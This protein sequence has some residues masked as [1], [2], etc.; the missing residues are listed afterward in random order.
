MDVTDLLAEAYGRLPDLVGAAVD[1]L[2]PEQLRQPP[3]PGANTVGWLIW[4]LTR[5]QD[6]GVADLLGEEQVWVS[7]DWAGR[8]GLTADPNDTG[9]GYTTEQVLACRPES[10]QALLD[11]HRAVAERTGAYLRGLRP[12]DLDR[13][14][15][16]NWD[17]PVTAG[18]R[19]ISL[20]E[21]NLQHAGQAAYVRGLI[22]PG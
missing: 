10:G 19:L 1:G 15:D 20:L 17:P 21:D 11:Y 22:E 2:G 5:I 13:V 4:H 7:G 14:V 12:G 9:F 18:V 16:E 3:A 8:F 6:S